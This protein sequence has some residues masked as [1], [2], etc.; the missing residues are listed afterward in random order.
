MTNLEKRYPKSFDVHIRLCGSYAWY[1]GKPVYCHDSS[2]ADGID[3]GVFVTMC[4]E[5]KPVK[6]YHIKETQKTVD[7][8][9]ELFDARPFKIGWTSTI[10]YGNT[11]YIMRQ[12]MRS[13]R[14]GMNI[15]NCNFFTQNRFKTN[16]KM[17]TFFNAP[18]TIFASMLRIYTPT[19]ES[20][21]DELSK[22]HKSVA[23]SPDIALF[24]SG[25]D[26]N[27]IELFYRWFSCGV[28]DVSKKRLYKQIGLDDKVLGKIQPFLVANNLEM[29]NV[30]S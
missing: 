18:G 20:A 19:F 25:K 12:P 1:D 22:S 17:S 15:N 11:I 14:A 13:Q 6:N 2:D 21:L 23:L 10:Y 26:L 7:P 16:V 8:N 28:I 30:G 9:S 24:R 4:D 3:P 27:F 29:V 5:I